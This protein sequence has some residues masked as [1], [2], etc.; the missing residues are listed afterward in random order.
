MGYSYRL[1]IIPDGLQGRVSSV[2][3]PATFGSQ[4][5]GLLLTGAL[6]DALGPVETVLV[7]FVPHFV[8]TTI[9]TVVLSRYP[10]AGLE[11]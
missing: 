6:L 1:A 5:F 3:C 2:P 9:A 8:L 4:A 7:L 11:E 10:N